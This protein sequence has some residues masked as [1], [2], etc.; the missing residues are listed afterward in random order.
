MSTSEYSLTDALAYDCPSPSNSSS[1]SCSISA[2]SF[3]SCSSCAYDPTYEKPYPSSPI[4][5]LTGKAISSVQGRLYEEGL[6]I[7]R[8]VNSAENIE[9]SSLSFISG[10]YGTAS[11]LR[12]SLS[13]SIDLKN[14][15][16]FTDAASSLPPPRRCF[17]SFCRSYAQAGYTFLP[18]AECR[19]FQDS[20]SGEFR[21]STV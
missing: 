21:H 20:N 8:L 2:L 9:V 12:Y 14:G 19:Q 5:S 10:R 13:Q 11:S 18:S 17:G 4:T 7:G 15:C 16:A 6:T 1:S 3:S